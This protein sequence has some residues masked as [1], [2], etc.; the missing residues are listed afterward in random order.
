MGGKRVAPTHSV[1]AAQTKEF[2]AGEILAEGV[3]FVLGVAV[4]ALPCDLRVL[5][6]QWC[7]SRLRYEH[8]GV[9]WIS[10]FGSG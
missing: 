4:T 9:R 8:C 6:Q 3:S 2:V 7:R 10:D 5:G 1:V